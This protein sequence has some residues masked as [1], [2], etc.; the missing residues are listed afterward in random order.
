[1][2]CLSTDACRNVK[3]SLLKVSKKT[4][5]FYYYTSRFLLLDN[6]VKNKKYGNFVTILV[7]SY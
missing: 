3:H 4:N 6:H 5:D 2:A 1:M 7:S